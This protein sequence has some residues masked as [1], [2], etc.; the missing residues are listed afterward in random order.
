MGR[1]YSDLTGV[2]LAGGRSVRMG[3]NKSLLM[4]DGMTIIERTV[5]L[6][7]SLFPKNFVSTN[8]P[9]DYEFLN[10]PTIADQIKNIGPLA[11]I[12][13]GLVHS[14]TEK[15]FVISCDMPLMTKETIQFLVE[16]LSARPITVARAD[17]FI[18]HLCGV[19]SKEVITDIEAL[20]NVDNI[21]ASEQKSGCR[22]LTKLNT[23]HSE[24]IDI[25]SINPR[26]T[27]GVFFNMN[28]PE[29]YQWIRE[30]YIR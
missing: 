14:S 22:V 8:T 24:T 11:G 1:M 27:E 10:V 15:I 20:V 6:M 18:Q 21:E 29:E 28:K 30:H 13:A 17:G 4:I 5:Q 25:K 7:R 12:H 26:Y 2:I 9:E 19:Y 16:Y 3:T 23:L